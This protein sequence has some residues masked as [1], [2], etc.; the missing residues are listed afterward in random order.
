MRESHTTFKLPRLRA[1]IEALLRIAPPVRT[2]PA[3]QHVEAM[4]GFLSLPP[5]VVIVVYVFVVAPL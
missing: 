4:W 1:F 3:G 2:V 5:P